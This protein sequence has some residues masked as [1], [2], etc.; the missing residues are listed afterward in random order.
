MH[1]AV[2]CVK[3]SGENILLNCTGKDLAPCMTVPTSLYW[4][5]HPNVKILDASTYS[6]TVQAGT[7]GLEPSTTRLTAARSTN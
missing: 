4:L 1:G 6:A 7:K 5:S 3:Y 2:L